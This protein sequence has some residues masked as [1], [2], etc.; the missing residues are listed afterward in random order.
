MR[1][2]QLLLAVTALVLS[3]CATETKHPLT[4]HSN[5][6]LT[7]E[8]FRRLFPIDDKVVD[9]ALQDY[10]LAQAAFLKKSENGARETVSLITS[11]GHVHSGYDEFFSSGERGLREVRDNYVAIQM[12]N[13]SCVQTTE[14]M[15]CRQGNPLLL[16]LV[17]IEKSHVSRVWSKD[18]SC[19][20]PAIA[21]RFI[22]IQLGSAESNIN[23]YDGYSSDPE[24]VGHDAEVLFT[25]PDHV[26]IYYKQTD[27]YHIGD[28][29]TAFYF[30]QF[31][32]PIKKIELPKEGESIS[33]D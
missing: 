3:A 6:P 23:S 21:C 31:D 5:T 22:K 18:L 15:K 27:H 26:P 4:E 32:L 8:Q 9:A 25:M 7:G 16:G 1:Y 30:F 2:Q 12:G 14:S 11:D 28:T 20:D 10:N 24:L 29:A 13:T 17:D 19:S 33:R